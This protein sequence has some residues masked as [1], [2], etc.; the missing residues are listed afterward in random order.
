MGIIIV[1]T[2]RAV[3]KWPKTLC[4]TVS[5]YNRYS[6]NHFLLIIFYPPNKHFLSQ[7]LGRF[8][9]DKRA[10][11]IILGTKSLVVTLLPDSLYMSWV[12]LSLATDVPTQGYTGYVCTQFCCTELMMPAQSPQQHPH[13][14]WRCEWMQS[15]DTERG[16]PAS[17]L[18]LTPCWV[19]HPS[20][21]LS[22]PE[23]QLSCH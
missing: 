20:L 3:L 14:L 21:P 9:Q 22:V 12:Y 4:V 8:H 11:L 10:H 19:S 1:F 18:P 7:T 2:D 17:Q 6:T 5:K 13:I 16:N 15:G 23:I